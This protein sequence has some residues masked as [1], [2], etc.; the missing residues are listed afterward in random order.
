MTRSTAAVA[1]Y[2][3]AATEPVIIVAVLALGCVQEPT[4]LAPPTY[5]APPPPPVAAE[6]LDGAASGRIGGHE[7]ILGG[8]LGRHAWLRALDGDS[9]R[10]VELP[11]TPGYEPV[12]AERLDGLMLLGGRTQPE[13]LHGP[14]IR[15]L[16]L[17]GAE[18]SIE[19][20]ESQDLE[21]DALSTVWANGRL[22]TWNWEQ[23]APAGSHLH[24]PF[25]LSYESDDE[26]RPWE[27]YGLAFV[28]SWQGLA[29][30]ATVPG[31][32]GKDELVL[33]APLQN[34]SGTGIWRGF[35][36]ARTLWRLSATIPE[37]LERPWAQRFGASHL[38]IGSR[39]DARVYAWHAPTDTW[40]SAGSLGAAPGDGPIRVFPQR[41]PGTTS[42]RLFDAILLIAY[43]GVVL[44]IGT[45]FARR[46]KGSA[47]WFIAGKRIPA[48]AAGCSILATQI[49]AITFLS[50]PAVAFA[51]DW[52]LLPS[53][54]GM[55]LFAPIA[56]F[57]FL[58]LFRK[59]RAPTAYSWL[60]ERF[61][62][63]V[64]LFGAAS[65]LVFQLARMGVVTY[66]PALA[67]AHATGLPHEAC[68]LICGAIAIL[69]TVFGGMEAVV[70]TDVLQAFA[71]FGGATAAIIVLVSGAGGPSEVW[72]AA[73]EAGKTRVWNPSWSVFTDAGWL[74]LLGGFFLQFGPYSADQAIV[75]RYL[76]TPDEKSAARAI[77]MN[78]WLSAPVG[79]LFLV[80][81]AGLWAWFRAHPERL[82]VGMAN[83]EVFPL[84]LTQ[85]LPPGVGG[86]ILAALA[87]AAMS[88]LDSGMHAC[89][90][91]LTHDFWLRLRRTLP[92]DAT[93]LLT[94]RKFAIAT[95][96]IG[97]GIALALAAGEVRS[98]LLFFLK[99]LGLV[100]SG[101]AGVF[102]LGVLVRRAGSLAALAG[103]A[104][105]TALLAWLAF[106]TSVH[107]FL[108]PLVGI[109]TCVVVGLLVSFAAP[110]RVVA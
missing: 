10:E 51:T 78:G 35:V 28:D 38:L 74:V 79:F 31:A 98:L 88:T 97:T 50:T 9:W 59:L 29:A 84:F 19:T 54:F 102:T 33:I 70:W 22:V 77:W 68:I 61:G 26:S 42:L 73:A 13:G 1:A 11:F 110:R 44:A 37:R 15:F 64:R 52:S 103:A 48:W 49:S 96:L 85:G 12:L 108:Y 100:M 62:L 67:I 3:S 25:F 104:A 65:F 34:G 27:V 66:L 81:G 36:P 55:L 45:Y 32:D 92:D 41:A 5:H 63:S 21:L 75:Q 72:S 46:E 90:T 83:D 101:V 18:L 43:L 6:L 39:D 82:E 94:A 20:T 53:W 23:R 60:E 14:L 71:I 91:V 87:A 57:V 47:D 86:L 30:L 107:L 24:V 106:G 76:S 69:Y 40:V 109:P 89:S 105:C 17:A 80:V 2:R 58:P 16:R 99:V 4:S 7:L 95:G 8:A 93:V 56:I